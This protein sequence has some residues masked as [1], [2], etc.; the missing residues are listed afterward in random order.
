MDWRTAQMIS[1]TRERWWSC[2]NVR[3]ASKIAL[4]ESKVTG[5]FTAFG[6]MRVWYHTCAWDARAKATEQPAYPHTL[7]GWRLAAGSG[8]LSCGR[9]SPTGAFSH[10]VASI[11]VFS[12]LSR[13]A[14]EYREQRG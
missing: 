4:G 2:A 11:I 12:P 7:K 6:C 1:P 9:F 8:S 13:S 10:V 5:S 14:H 3:R